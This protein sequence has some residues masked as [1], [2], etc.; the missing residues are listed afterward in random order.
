MSPGQSRRHDV[1]NQPGRPKPG[2]RA[3]GGDLVKRPDQSR[4]RQRRCEVLELI[5]Q[6]RRL[7]PVKPPSSA[8]F[9]PSYSRALS[10]ICALHAKGVTPRNERS[11]L[12]P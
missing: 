5:I 3:L 6:Y 2:R 10:E 1:Q 8:D 7:R 11:A 4:I 12:C 9:N